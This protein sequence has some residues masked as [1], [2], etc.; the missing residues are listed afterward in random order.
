MPPARIV[1]LSEE[2]TEVLYR[3]GEQD[4]IVGVTAYTVRPPQARREKPVV[5]AFID[6]RIEK[7]V[8]LRPDLVIAF[9]D[10]Q[11]DIVAELLRRGLEVHAFNQRTVQEILEFVRTLG[12][13]VG[14]AEAGGALA[15][16]LAAHV[17]LVRER[18][19]ALPVRPRVYFEEWPDPLITSIKWVAELIET[20]GG[21]YI[22]PELCGG[23]VARE[24]IVADPAAILARKPDLMLASWCGK[25]LEPERV[26][27]RPGWAEAPFLRAG[28]LREIDAAII[29]QPG[30][31]ALTD[32]VDALHAAIAE[33]AA[34]LAAS[35]SK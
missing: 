27:A 28:R 7:I 13:L 5:A 21:E 26:A 32:G 10:L 29:L 25:P 6:A 23:R 30:P 31:A 22:F 14:R 11:A 17:A 2:S 8:E 34:D 18:A 20:A 15:D 33:T 35:G 4:R 19:A 16:E 12:A 24:R 3:L 9:S 1:C